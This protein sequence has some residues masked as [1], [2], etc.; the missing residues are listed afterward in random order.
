M[1]SSL[2]ENPNRKIGEEVISKLSIC[3][4]D[5]LFAKIRLPDILIRF[6]STLNRVY[7][8]EYGKGAFP[9]TGCKPENSVSEGV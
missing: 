5:I 1:S 6:F 9:L 4:Y 8:R 2:G 3:R 7:R